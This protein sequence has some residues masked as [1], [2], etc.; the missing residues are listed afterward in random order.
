MRGVCDRDRRGSISGGKGDIASGGSRS[1]WCYIVVSVTFLDV[2]FKRRA[3]SKIPIAAQLNPTV[4]S[5]ADA[6]KSIGAQFNPAAKFLNPAFAESNKIA[7][8]PAS[9]CRV[10]R[11]L[12]VNPRLEV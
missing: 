4:Q 1:N 5:A 11:G 9:L 7:V 3:D 12:F 2:I 8:N 6:K 10:I